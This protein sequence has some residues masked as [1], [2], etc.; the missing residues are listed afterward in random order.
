M[1]ICINKLWGS[2]CYSSSGNR[3]S[4]YWDVNDGRV[5]CRNL[6]HQELGINVMFCFF[7]RNVDYCPLLQCHLMYLGLT[8]YQRASTIFGQGSGPIFLANIRCSGSEM[9]LLDC[10]RTVFV[11]IECTHSRDV[12][13]KCQRKNVVMYD[14][15]LSCFSI[16]YIA[17]GMFTVKHTLLCTCCNFFYVARCE[18]GLVRI[19]NSSDNFNS[20][21]GRVE[22]CVNGT[23]GTICSDFW[24]N[25]DASVVCKQVGYSYYGK[26]MYISCCYL[27]EVL[28]AGINNVGDRNPE[29]KQLHHNTC[30]VYILSPAMLSFLLLI[31]ATM[32]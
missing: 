3:Y 31:I 30:Q 25:Q 9:S 13:V 11:G 21:F 4:N 24:D 17:R 20:S 10:P 15:G 7:F 2:I 29:S 8:V 5:A 19:S 22:V 18:N 23:W 12:G 6:D 1:E 26:L 16:F 28:L 27:S 32:V 14:Y